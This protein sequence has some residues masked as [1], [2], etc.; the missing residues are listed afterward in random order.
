M[1]YSMGALWLFFIIMFIVG[2]IVLALVFFVKKV[3]HSLA[4][5]LISIFVLVCGLFLNHQIANRTFYDFNNDV[6][7]AHPEIEEVEFNLLYQGQTCALYVWMKEAI[8]DE[9]IE[10]LFID[11]L[12]RINK[13]PLSSYIKNSANSERL[14]IKIDFSGGNHLIFTSKQYLRSEWF[15]E[16]NQKVQTWNGD[17]THKIYHYSDYSN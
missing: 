7:A 14:I 1:T 15:T 10:N 5:L 3:K 9:D 4:Y 17:D 16:D 6:C 11:L 8:S 12:K 13:E 2:T